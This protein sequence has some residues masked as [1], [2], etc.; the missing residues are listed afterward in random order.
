M[1]FHSHSADYWN[2]IT[3]FFLFLFFSPLGKTEEECSFHSLE[4]LFPSRKWA[5]EDT[6]VTLPWSNADDMGIGYG[7]QHTHLFMTFLRPLC[8]SPESVKQYCGVNYTQTAHLAHRRIIH[9]I[10]WRILTL[11]NALNKKAWYLQLFLWV[12]YITMSLSHY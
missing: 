12:L 7:M 8:F 4:A 9:S 10:L 2:A 5:T 1:I 6:K 3:A 11:A